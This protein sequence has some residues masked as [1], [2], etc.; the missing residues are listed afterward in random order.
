MSHTTGPAPGLDDI[1]DVD[2]RRVMN[3]VS[4]FRNFALTEVGD[5]TLLLAVYPYRCSRLPSGRPG[6]RSPTP[7]QTRRRTEM[8]EKRGFVIVQDQGRAT[9]EARVVQRNNRFFIEPPPNGEE[10][11]QARS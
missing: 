7:L 8:L 4:S 1:L 3:A 6:S 5:E 11:R 10:E 9:A 2:A